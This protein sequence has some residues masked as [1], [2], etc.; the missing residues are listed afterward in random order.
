MNRHYFDTSAMMRFL[1][2]WRTADQVSCVMVTYAEARAALAQSL[3]QRSVTASRH[4]RLKSIWDSLWPDLDIVEV[5]QDLVSEA[6]RLAERHGLRGYDAV[7]LARA[8]ATCWSAPTTRSA[9]PR[10]GC[11]SAS[12]T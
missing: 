3:R 12:S 2:A 5:D 11:A 4:A 6:G 1:R 7:Q 10:C 8:T 9:Q